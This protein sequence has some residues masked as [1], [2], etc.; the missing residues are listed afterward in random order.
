[1]RSE[2][3][4]QLT[5]DGSTYE[6]K[7]YD[8][9]IFWLKMMERRDEPYYLATSFG[10][11]SIAAQRLCDEAGVKYEAHHNHT[12]ADP[13]EL[14]YFGRRHYPE[15][16]RHYPSRNMWQLIVDKGIFPLR[17]MRFCCD[18]LKERGGRRRHCV[19]G[20]RMEESVRRA[21]T[22]G[23]VTERSSNRKQVHRLFV[24]NEID[25]FIAECSTKSQIVVAPLFHWPKDV[26]WNFIR[27]RS[28]PY[29]EL[30]DQGYD[31]LGCIMCPMAPERQR[32]AEALRWPGFYRLYLRA[33]QRL[34]DAGRFTNIGSAE[35][36][37]EWWLSE[38]TQE[39][40]VD[41]DQE[42]MFDEL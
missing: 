32:R 10:K 9:A 22:W 39:E 28:L 5:I 12:T 25:D 14:V 27:D 33:A 7:L 6:Q 26:L 29:C 21:K 35:A 11:D 19:M 42:T 17:H 13:P 8:D 2:M 24:A 31:R 4:E 40:S 36:I 1:M 15:V 18:K 37:M 3:P 23:P 30:Y 38:R 34:T 20:I 16:I 41:E